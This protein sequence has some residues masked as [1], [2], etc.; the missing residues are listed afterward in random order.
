M[1]DT[2]KPKEWPSWVFVD[3]LDTCISE[4]GKTVQESAVAPC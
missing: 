3:D 1:R 4:G 2:V